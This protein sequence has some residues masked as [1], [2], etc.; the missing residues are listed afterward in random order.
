VWCD[1]GAAR[2]AMVRLRSFEG[3]QNMEPK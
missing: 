3:P 1:E 2:S